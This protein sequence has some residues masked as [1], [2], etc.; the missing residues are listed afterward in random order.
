MPIHFAKLTNK[1]VFQTRTKC[2]KNSRLVFVSSRPE[3]ITCKECLKR[4]NN[5]KE[6][7]SINS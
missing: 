2:G 3:N 5:E 7:D 1:Q 4:L 6:T